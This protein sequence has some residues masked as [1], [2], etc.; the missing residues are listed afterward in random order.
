MNPEYT[1]C[2]NCHQRLKKNGYQASD[3]H[4]VFSDHKINLQ[5]HLCKNPGC[6]LHITPSIKS[7][8]GSNIHPDLAKVQCEQGAL[9]SYREA[10]SNLEKVNTKRRRVN[11]HTQIKAIT[12]QVGAVLSEDNYYPLTPDK[13]AAPATEVIVQIDGGHI[14]TKDKDQRSFEAL[15]GIVY[16]PENIQNVDRHH[17]EIID[18]TCVILAQDDE[19]ETMKTY[20]VNAAHKQGMTE[21]SRV[22]AL[23]DGAR[24]CW[25]VISVLQ[26]L[27][28]VLECILDWFHIGKK[29]QSIK[30]A[31]AESIDESLDRAKWKLWH[32]QADEALRHLE[33]LKDNVTDAQKQSQLKSLYDY[34]KRNRAYVLNYAEPEQADQTYTSQVAESHIESVINAH[35]KKKGKMQWTRD[36]AHNVLQIRASMIGTEWISRWQE[37]VLRSM[38]TAA[39]R[40]FLITLPFSFGSLSSLP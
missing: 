14:P 2:P 25:S 22:T 30:N 3:F 37:T 27:C 28:Q 29:F 10:Q 31:L 7:I 16:R 38:E 12:N 13:C 15:A 19:L 6:T 8:F 21:D 9:H 34:L 36:G 18:K 26:P 40:N 17:W 4:A 11:N 33:L 1:L 32:G 23:A 20:L 24:N 35:H 5:K 39:W